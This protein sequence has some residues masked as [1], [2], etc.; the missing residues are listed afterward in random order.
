MP[1]G[2]GSGTGGDG[3]GRTSPGGCGSPRSPP[4]AASVR[5]S[6]PGCSPSPGNRVVSCRSP[7]RIPRG[8][9]PGRRI[10][11]C[12]GRSLGLGGSRPPGSSGS[13]SKSRRSVG[14]WRVGSD[15]PVSSWRWAIGPSSA[16]RFSASRGL[17]IL[18]G[19]GLVSAVRRPG[20][21]PVVTIRDPSAGPGPVGHTPLENRDGETLRTRSLLR[22]RPAHGPEM[23]DVHMQV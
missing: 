12:M 23:K 1:A 6:W 18:A 2:A 17:D 19:A 16:P 14:S 4:D 20:Q 3:A 10:G 5:R 11:R 8:R 21:S 7:S 13:P 15:R 9:T 22:G